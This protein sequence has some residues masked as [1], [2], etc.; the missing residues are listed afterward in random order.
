MNPGAAKT[1]DALLLSAAVVL[2]VLVPPAFAIVGLPIAAA[3]LA[4][5]AYQ[6]RL[7]NAAVAVAVGIALVAL[8]QGIGAAYV[9]P[10]LA[11]IAL[12][13]ILLPRIDAQ[14]VGALLTA[15]LGSAEAVHDYLQ[16]RAMHQTPQQAITRMVDSVSSST[17]TAQMKL[18]TAK[19]LYELLP[20]LY[21]VSGLLAAIVVILAVAWAARRSNRT[22]KV[23]SLA[24]LDLT[25]HVLWPFIVGV[26]AVAASYGRVPY[27]SALWTVGLNFVVCVS[28]LFALQGVG[29]VAGMLDRI[30]VGRGV[31]VWAW[32]A[33]AVFDVFMPVASFVGLLDFWVNFRRLPRDG[34]N[35]PSPTTAMSDR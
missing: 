27:S 3:G 30:S 5:L 1:R 34:A 24:K 11:A 10:A 14:W 7:V 32:V 21:F 22:L 33:L 25:P 19:L 15:V 35:P 8:V 13:V 12:A 16:I 17:A 28:V 31:R 29:V 4:G 9:A 6:R 23:P 26:L 20:M 2:G 18:D